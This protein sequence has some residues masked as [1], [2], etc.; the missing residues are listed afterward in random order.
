VDKSTKLA[1][2]RMYKN[3]SSY[4]ARDFLLRLYFLLDEGMSNLV[5]IRPAP[6]IILSL[7]THQFPLY[8]QV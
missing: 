5:E 8:N 7:H 1:F 2:A 3:N 4:S 6:C